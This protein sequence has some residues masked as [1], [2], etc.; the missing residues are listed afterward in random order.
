MP[1]K[2]IQQFQV[3]YIQILDEEG[4]VD[5]SMMPEMNDDM[6][7]EMYKKMCMVRKFDQKYFKL[8]RAGKIGTYAEV[9]GQEAA[10]VGSVMAAEKDD[11]TVPT[12][13]ETGVLL[14]RGVPGSTLLQGWKGDHKAFRGEDDNRDLPVAVPVGSQALHGAGIGWAERLKEG[15]RVA[16]TYFGDGATSQG[17]VNEAFNFAGVFKANTIFICQNNHW[18]IST[19]NNRQTA[20][21]TMAQKAIAFGFPGIKVDGND[22]LAMYA[23]TKDAVERAR[24]GEGPTLIEAATYRIGDHTTSDDSSKY[25]K[26]EEV[27]EWKKK[28]PIKRLRLYMEKKGI[29]NEEQENSMQEELDKHIAEEAEKGVAIPQ[30]P[31]EELFENIYAEPPKDYVE[32]KNEL[33]EAFKGDQQ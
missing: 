9:H 18:A 13:R 25:R 8:Q 33:A 11:W 17:E 10:Q 1:R 26:P 7:K 19:P 12:F 21:E 30:P 29:W 27:E 20:A 2:V 14:A 31:V 16:L 22:I 15:D 24:K 32:Q 6:L 3:E 28:C 5:D 23:V 4:N